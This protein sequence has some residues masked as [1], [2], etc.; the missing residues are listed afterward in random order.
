MKCDE[1]VIEMVKARG[2]SLLSY[3]HI[4]VAGI[5]AGPGRLCIRKVEK[6]E[7]QKTEEE[8][9]KPTTPGKKK[10]FKQPNMNLWFNKASL[11]KEL[12]DKIP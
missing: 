8:Q 3:N 9:S 12:K 5:G 1:V 2:N 7:E 11:S 4:P 6:E 10:Q